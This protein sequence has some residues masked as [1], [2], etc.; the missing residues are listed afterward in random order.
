MR[1]QVFISYSHAD[2]RWLEKL[3][4]HLK[5]FERKNRIQVWA[6]T[7]IEAGA[8]WRSEIE[9]ALRSARVAVLLV[10]PN[11]LASDFIVDHELP[12]LLA[13]AQEEGLTILWVAVSASAFT[14]TEIKDYQAT[15]D[16]AKPLDTLKSASLNKQLVKIC[17]LISAAMAGDDDGDEDRNGDGE[18]DDGGGDGGR[19]GSG[20]DATSETSAEDQEPVAPAPAKPTAAKSGTASK[21]VVQPAR[22]NTRPKLFGMAKL[23][24]VVLA[25]VVLLGVG[26]ILAFSKRKRE[27]PPPPPL[28]STEFNDHF[29]NPSHWQRP[30]SG[31]STR[32]ERLQIENQPQLGYIPDKNYADFEMGFHLTLE[33]AKGA[34]WAIR[35]QPDTRSYY[36]FYLSGPDGQSRNRF[37]TYIVHDNKLDPA[38]PKDST[39]LTEKPEI[40]GQ[41]QITVIV[42]GNQITH[43]IESAQSGNATNLGDFT[44]QEN[45]FASGTVGFRTIGG[46]K[47]SVDDLYIRPPNIKLPE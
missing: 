31:W 25:I 11:F 8:K 28:T 1:D 47:F 22:R 45:S 40:N 16:P 10:S 12:V 33:N 29:D 21:R 38:I 3:R 42:K 2:Q 26:G 14:E 4:V 19:S 6:D 34:A 5:P 20:S 41:Y 37:L 24:W 43:K 35:V 9:N 23:Y 18:G 13:A 39:P 17:E 36:L 32:D 44:D 46:E 7:K 15:N 30:A 27:P